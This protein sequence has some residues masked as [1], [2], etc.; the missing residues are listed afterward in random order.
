MLLMINWQS[1]Y[2]VSL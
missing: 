1:E 2:I